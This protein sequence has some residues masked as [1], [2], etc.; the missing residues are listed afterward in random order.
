MNGCVGLCLPDN[1]AV[2]HLDCFCITETCYA[3]EFS[4]YIKITVFCDLMPE[5]GDS[6]FLRNVGIF[7]PYYKVS[8]FRQ[9]GH[10]KTIPEIEEEENWTKKI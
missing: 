9:C 2:V 6:K 10:L 5:D 1:T 4:W 3:T 7:L 8:I